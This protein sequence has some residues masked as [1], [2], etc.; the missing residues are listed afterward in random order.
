MGNEASTNQY[1]SGIA[2]QF[3]A[4]NTFYQDCKEMKSHKWMIQKGERHLINYRE[5]IEDEE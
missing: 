3:P 1:E 4:R 2:Q 5:I